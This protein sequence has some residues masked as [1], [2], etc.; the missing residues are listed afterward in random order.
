MV[1]LSQAGQVYENKRVTGSI[2][3][4][5]PDVTIRN[6]ELITTNPGY[7]VSVKRAN[8]WERADAGLVLD[9]VE[10]D[11]NG[12]YSGK[13]IAFNGYTARNVFFHN[14]SDCAHFS[15]DVVIEDSLCVVGPDANGDAWPDGTAF[16]SG[17]EH[18]DG[19]QSDGGRGIVVRHNTIRN[20]CGQTSAILLSSNTSPIRDVTVTGNLLTGGGYALYCNAGPDVANETVTGNRFARSWHQRGGYWGATTGCEDADVF[21]GNVWDDTGAAL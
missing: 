2:V 7:A 19:L 8:S 6:V 9:H 14:G 16:C 10:I 17:T 20:P 12:G 21:T 18:F 11:M 13:G 15:E 4:T 1:T 3:V 5:A